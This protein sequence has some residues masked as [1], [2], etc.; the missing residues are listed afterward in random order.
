MKVI[1]TLLVALL[2]FTSF[3]P[4]V[5]AA[6]AV[7]FGPIVPNGTN[8]QPDCNC[9]GSAPDYG[10]VLQT[11]QNA[12]NITITF[13]FMLMIL[14]IAIAGFQFVM[15]AGNSEA[16]SAAKKRLLNTL[17]GILVV[18][19]AWLIVDFV[20]KTLYGADGKFGPWNAILQAESGD[21][22][23]LE[24]TANPPSFAGV[25][26]GDPGAPTTGPTAPGG[27]GDN[28]P[29]A[30]PAS[31]V[32]FPQSV[33]VDGEPEKATAATVNNF[34]AMRE[35]ALKDGVNLKVIDGYR[36]E[37][38]QVYLWNKY[39]GSGTCGSTKVARPCTMNGSGSNHNSGVALDITVGGCGNGNTCSTKEYKW[40]KE[41]GGTWHFY[42][43]VPTDP[44]HWSPSGR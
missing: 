39:C 30:D 13:G 36:S 28:C 18:M 17:F 19:S 6:D 9:P 26:G 2:A 37:S 4:S 38:E 41:H 25:V 1:P 7:F 27:T 14:F 29:A 44:V 35:A 40:L 31:M 22:V 12:I 23:C 33:V 20:M 11:I 10:C 16:H 3:A 21:D 24:K 32:P 42:N 8:G 43:N 5:L 15:S 34:L